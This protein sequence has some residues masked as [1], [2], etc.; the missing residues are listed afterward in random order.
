MK[1]LK[2]KVKN[3]KL[4]QKIIANETPI[5]YSGIS[6][7]FLTDLAHIAEHG[8]LLEQ[9]LKVFY[10]GQKIDSIIESYHENRTY[11]AD[12][13]N[14]YSCD[15][16]V[17]D[18]SNVE[19]AVEGINKSGG[20]HT[21]RNFRRN[22]IS[23]KQLEWLEAEFDDNYLGELFWFW[24]EQER[25]CLVE[26]LKGDFKDFN[27]DDVGFYGRSGGHFC[28]CNEFEI[29]YEY[30]HPEDF[31]QNVL[32]IDDYVKDEKIDNDAVVDYLDLAT[33]TQDNA[34]KHLKEV[35]KI[36]D[37][38]E[39]NAGE[40]D[41]KWEIMY[42]VEEKIENDLDEYYEWKLNNE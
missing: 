8:G 25:E 7:D 42:R 9:V 24:I 4:A 39:K 33:E 3:L 36:L 18:W 41:L 35:E 22:P 16:K 1:L 5:N 14:M 32:R 11:Y 23:E 17:R 28:L 37:H 6:D 21:S 26:W 15:V 38:V 27:F 34:L 31:I 19:E 30:D 20:E 13:T 29:E 10:R 40:L 2:K 12:R